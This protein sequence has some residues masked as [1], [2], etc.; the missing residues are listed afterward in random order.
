MMCG[1]QK[2]YN[3]S[4]DRYL[5]WSKKIYSPFLIDS[6]EQALSFW[7]EKYKKFIYTFIMLNNLL[8]P[9]GKY[10]GFSWIRLIFWCMV[11][12]YSLQFFTLD[13]NDGVMDAFIH[14]PNLIFHEAGHVVFMPVGEFLRILGGSL[15]QCLM[16]LIVML[17]FLFKE[18][19]PFG[20]SIGLWWLGQN[21][22]DVALYIS[23]AWVRSLPLIGGM[24]EEA[25]DWGNLLTMMNLLKYDHLFGLMSHYLGMAI[26]ILALVW[27]GYIMTFTWIHRDTQGSR[28]TL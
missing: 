19:D 1:I 23:D 11:I 13:V 16:P 10:A 4:F 15:G 17:V 8:I 12:F 18:D 14:G 21:L 9:S 28:D 22:T 20:A 27:G 25:H 2:F 3:L 6:R 24:S 5:S 7:L 26:M